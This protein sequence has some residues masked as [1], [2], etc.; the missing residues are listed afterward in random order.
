[1]LGRWELHTHTFEGGSHRPRNGVRVSLRAAAS[2]GCPQCPPWNFG[3]AARRASYYIGWARPRVAVQLSRC[4]PCC[5]IRSRG[6]AL[7]GGAAHDR[8]LPFNC[9]LGRFSGSL[10]AWR[11]WGPSPSSTRTYPGPGMPQ[12]PTL[13]RQ[14]RSYFPS[15]GSAAYV[16]VTGW[17]ALSIEHRAPRT[18]R[19]IELGLLCP[20]PDVRATI[21]VL[22]LALR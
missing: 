22:L 15:R 10:C 5:H 8:I 14:V 1:M 9:P 18:E 4:P 19:Q 11:G 2:E 21:P 16:S 17:T 7:P 13:G 12:L 20:P 3:Y 6:P